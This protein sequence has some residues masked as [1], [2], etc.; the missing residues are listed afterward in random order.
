MKLKCMY[1]NAQ[2]LLSKLDELKIIKAQLE[3]DIVCR[4]EKLLSKKVDYREVALA[5]FQPFRKD[6]NWLGD[7]ANTLAE[8]RLQR[9]RSAAATRGV[10]AVV[11]EKLRET[12]NN[13]RLSS[14]ERVQVLPLIGKPGKNHPP[15]VFTNLLSALTIKGLK[16]PTLG[17]RF[18][19]KC[20]PFHKGSGNSTGKHVRVCP[21]VLT[22]CQLHAVDSLSSLAAAAL[23]TWN[24]VGPSHLTPLILADSITGKDK[25]D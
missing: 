24:L 7:Q 12:L 5:G 3:S 19:W 4:T 11:L 21:C 15:L 20:P 17:P 16:M 8:L 14:N 9:R 13:M 2:S 22:T 6:F 25:A 10:N 23:L 18:R 1:T